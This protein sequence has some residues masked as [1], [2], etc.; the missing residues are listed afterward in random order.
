M[1]VYLALLR[2]GHRA[3]VD[4]PHAA[5]L[6]VDDCHDGVLCPDCDTTRTIVEILDWPQGRGGEDLQVNVDAERLQPTD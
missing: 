3:D 5:N 4:Q 6:A 2:C 1:T